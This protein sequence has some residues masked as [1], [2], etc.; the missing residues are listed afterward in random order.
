MARVFL[1]SASA[2]SRPELHERKA[3]SS[4]RQNPSSATAVAMRMPSAALLA[5]VAA[6]R[7]VIIVGR[8]R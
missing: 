5:V 6:R 7:G 1:L 2:C 4:T 3:G 8:P